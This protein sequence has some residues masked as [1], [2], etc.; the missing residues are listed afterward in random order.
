MYAEVL[1][2]PWMR[3]SD[4]LALAEIAHKGKALL[5]IDNTFLSPAV[6]RPLELGADL[7]LHATTKWLSG[8]GDAIGG[9][10]A[11]KKVLIDPIRRQTDL[12]GQAAS[13]F[14]SW[15]IARGARTLPLR[16]E[17]AAENASK[18]AALLEA[19]PKVEWVRHP[20][21]ASHPDRAVADKVLRGS[22]GGMLAFK[23]R[24][25]E[26]VDPLDAM[27]AFSDHLRIFGVAVSLGEVDTLV[28]PMPK[29]GGIF[30]ISVG[31]ESFDD[32][33]AEFNQALE[34]VR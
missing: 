27:R 8:H 1:S 24:A 33:A 7:V 29:R 6:V 26:G 32:I 15:L 11:G 2:N 12:L 25:V 31:I 28:Y 16:I 3:V 18:L 17:R 20:S 23:P 19:H 4:L 34:H 5:V 14:N 22:W 9:V 13:P 30:R 21:L 10:V